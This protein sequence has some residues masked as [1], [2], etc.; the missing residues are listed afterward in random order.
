MRI[1][2]KDGAVG[3]DV[4]RSP[5]L[6]LAYRRYPARRETCGPRADQLGEASDQLQLRFL[7]RNVQSLL[8]EAEGFMQVWMSIER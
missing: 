7:R 4:R 8:E 3:T 2:I 6:L 5:A 1:L